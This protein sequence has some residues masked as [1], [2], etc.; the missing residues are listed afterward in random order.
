MLKLM[1]DNW[2]ICFLFNHRFDETLWRRLD[3]ANKTLKPGVVGRV[4]DRGVAVLR[5]AKSEVINLQEGPSTFGLSSV[6]LLF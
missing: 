2:N 6:R 1:H 5:L 3:L 4:L